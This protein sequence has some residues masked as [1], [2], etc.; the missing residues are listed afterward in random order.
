MRTSV[1]AAAL[2]AVA[3]GVAGC[4]SSTG[5][6]AVPTYPPVPS[7]GAPAPAQRSGTGGVRG[8]ITEENG[9]TWTV[10]TATGRAITVTLNGQTAFGTKAAPGTAAQFPVGAQ[11]RVTGTRTGT[12]IT[13]TRIATP[14]TPPPTGAAAP[15][16]A[17]T[18]APA[19]TYSA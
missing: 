19:V 18:A 10:T 5:S 12:A 17:A 6:D 11:V 1:L 3:L 2:A 14:R 7:T 15:T 9:S 4:G 16:P 13:A 8:Q